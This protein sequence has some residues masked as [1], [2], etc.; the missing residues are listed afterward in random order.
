MKFEYEAPDDPR[1]RAVAYIDKRGDLRIRERE[2]NEC[3]GM[4]TRG[5]VW[6]DGCFD[7]SEGVHVFYPGDKITITF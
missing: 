5:T 4:S 6:G 1:R 7:L 2:G 3:I